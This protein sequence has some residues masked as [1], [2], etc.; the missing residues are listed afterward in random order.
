MDC[1]GQ[2][3]PLCTA[4]PLHTTVESNQAGRSQPISRSCQFFTQFV[5]KPTNQGE[6][7]PVTKFGHLSFKRVKCF[8]VTGLSYSTW[9]NWVNEQTLPRF[10]SLLWTLTLIS[11]FWLKTACRWYS[12]R[13]IFCSSKSEPA[14]LRLHKSVPRSFAC[15]TLT[16][17]HY[18]C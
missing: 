15:N 10:L 2:S 9:T 18:Y 6:G 1:T 13:F 8:P 16:A 7:W 14:A 12:F 5:P 17:T 3:S 4:V 11:P